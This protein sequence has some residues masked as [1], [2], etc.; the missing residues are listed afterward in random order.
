MN[1]NRNEPQADSASYQTTA[2]TTSDPLQQPQQPEQQA[3]TNTGERKQKEEETTTTG[4]GY[5]AQ[6]EPV[7]YRNEGPTCYEGDKSNDP[8]LMWSPSIEPIIFPAEYRPPSTL[9][10]ALKETPLSKEA[11]AELVRSCA[12]KPEEMSPYLWL[13]TTNKTFRS[14]FTEHLMMP[15]NLERLPWKGLLYNTLTAL[16]SLQQALGTFYCVEPKQKTIR[17]RTVTWN[18]FLYV[19]DTP[20][21]FAVKDLDTS[22]TVYVLEG[23]W[24]Y[25]VGPSLFIM[26]PG[27]TFYVSDIST[28]RNTSTVYLTMSQYEATYSIFQAVVPL[29]GEKQQAAAQPENAPLPPIKQSYLY[30]ELLNV[31]EFINKS[32]DYKN[33]EHIALLD[34]LVK[35]S[36]A[37]ITNRDFCKTIVTTIA[38]T[39]KNSKNKYYAQKNS[40]SSN[41]LT[42]L[43]CLLNLFS[44]HDSETIR[45][46][47]F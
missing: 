9:E 13:L 23:S 18:S 22:H 21:V 42:S 5:A 32:F 19:T 8:S 44:T 7:F 1:E 35:K 43:L 38:S 14:M 33:R 20:D 36:T 47:D 4:E 41:M 16:R 34:T 24:G 39:V 17:N 40:N 2:T 45:A 26:E 31:C 11:A 25:F 27:S 15:C 46:K 3:G 29:N 30:Q 28:N 37:F 10:D 6:S 12:S